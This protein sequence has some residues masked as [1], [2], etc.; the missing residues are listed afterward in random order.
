[1]TPERVIDFPSVTLTA[2]AQTWIDSE[3]PPIPL[4]RIQKPVVITVKYSHAHVVKPVQMNTG[5]RSATR[6]RLREIFHVS[7]MSYASPYC[8]ESGTGL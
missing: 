8:I 7:I 5:R 3:G 6:S 1:M 2:T 4:A